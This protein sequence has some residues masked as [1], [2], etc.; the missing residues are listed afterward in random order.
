[1]IEIEKFVQLA[2]GRNTLIPELI[3]T[4]RVY[5]PAEPHLSFIATN[6]CRS[7]VSGIDVKGVNNL[8]E[9]SDLKKRGKKLRVP[10]N[11]HSDADHTAKRYILEE[12]GFFDLANRLFFLGGF[13][14]LERPETKRFMPAENTVFV[15]TPGDAHDLRRALRWIYQ[16][17]LTE[18]QKG[19]VKTYQDNCRALTEASSEAIKTQMNL[20]NVLV[21]YPEGTRTRD[22][23][24]WLGKAPKEVD[25][26]FPDDEETW[27]LPM[28]TKGTANI[29]TLN[30]K[31]GSTR[32]RLE[33]VVGRPYPCKQ[34]YEEDISKISLRGFPATRAD[35]V[36]ARLAM[37][38]PDLVAPEDLEFYKKVCGNY[39]PRRDDG[40]YHSE[41]FLDRLQGSPLEDL[42]I[43]ARAGLFNLLGIGIEERPDLLK[44][45]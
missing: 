34:I 33:M 26:L 29:M 22:K 27:I 11:H 40:V 8:R 9:A 24:G 21:F 23:N 4:G 42:S 36:M 19:I 18:E 1:M 37:L 44:Q 30:D 17:K 35:V 31:F 43:G 41:S 7:Y 16:G 45:I 13:K 5:M 15:I 14:M 32:T 39:N 38:M 2:E 3:R 28:M 10:S 25:K 6:L 20:G 12:L